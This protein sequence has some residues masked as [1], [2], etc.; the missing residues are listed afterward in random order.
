MM[1]GRFDDDNSYLFTQSGQALTINGTTAKSYAAAA[2]N[3]TTSLI[4][5]PSHGFATG[6][7]VQ[8]EGIATNGLRGSNLQNTPL[9]HN[10]FAISTA[11]LSGNV[12]TINTTTAHGF[13]TSQS[14]LISNIDSTFNGIYTIASASGTQFTYAKT[15]TDV[16][17]FSPTGATASTSGF[18]NKEGNLTNAGTYIVYAPTT[19][20]VGLF[21]RTTGVDAVTGISVAT[22]EQSTTTVTITTAT[23]HGLVT[24]D[25]VRLTGLTRVPN[26]V[27]A[28]TRT[29]DTAFTYTATTATV[30]SGADTAGRVYELLDFT[31]PGNTQYTYFL[32]PNGSLN[33]T[34]GPNYQ[35][36]I[37]LRL[38]PSVS[39]GLT[40]KLGD[41]DVI[42]RMQLRLKEIGISTTQ[43]LDVKVLLNPRLNNL[44]FQSVDAPSLTQI[45]EHTNADTVSG[46]VQ[47]Y[48]FR[49]AGGASGAEATTNVD[50]SSLF[51]LSNSILGGDS[52]FP[53]GPD[54]LTIAV[55]RLTG[56]S[57]LASA[58]L[59]WS[60][61][62]A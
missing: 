7:L 26:Y 35:P 57:T 49:A 24:G 15:A 11:A 16:T 17:S 58:K 51:E 23:K 30:A 2:V 59:S 29:S 45:V 34:S 10:S 44:N 20:T 27:G 53:D 48:N 40:G 36:L 22:S 38:S 8:Y 3:S 9:L 61:A 50:V 19:S 13:T 25:V 12:A 28:I 6:D 47:V 54:I 56:S 39:S 4:T 18:Y 55:S 43:L 37:S 31:A 21:P 32:Y 1:D 33:N 52:I 60:E 46:G 41:R 5:I 62:Q 42:N 14:V